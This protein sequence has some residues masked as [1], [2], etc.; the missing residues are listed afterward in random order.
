MQRPHDKGNPT[1]RIFS[2]IFC[3]LDKDIKNGD[4]VASNL[5]K[6]N[7]DKTQN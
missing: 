7:Q 6:Y 5:G 4:C 1:E 3:F 2:N